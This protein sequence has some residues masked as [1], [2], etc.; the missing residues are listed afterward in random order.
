MTWQPDS[1]SVIVCYHSGVKQR[2]ICGTKQEAMEIWRQITDAM[3]LG[4]PLVCI[5]DENENGAIAFATVAI[6]S[7]STGASVELLRVTRPAELAPLEEAEHVMSR[8]N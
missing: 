7:V 1:T 4:L 6:A 8:A 5:E 2:L 3:S